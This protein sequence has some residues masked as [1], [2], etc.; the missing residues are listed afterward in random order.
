MNHKVIKLEN[1]SECEVIGMN[2]SRG[3]KMARGRTR[4][5]LSPDDPRT[6]HF[7]MLTTP[8]E[9]QNHQSNDTTPRRFYSQQRKNHGF[10]RP[11]TPPKR[12]TDS[13]SFE[14]PQ[15]SRNKPN[16]R[17]DRY[18]RYEHSPR[19][20]NDNRY[21]GESDSRRNSSSTRDVRRRQSPSM[22]VNRDE[23]M[24]PERV[25]YKAFKQVAGVYGVTN[26]LNVSMGL[27]HFLNQKQNESSHLDRQLKEI[28]EKQ[29]EIKACEQR[30]ENSRRRISVQK[31]IR[32]K[33]P[34]YGMTSYKNSSSN[35]S[36]CSRNL[37]KEMNE[38][39]K[40][41]DRRHRESKKFDPY[42]SRNYYRSPEKEHRKPEEKETENKRKA[43]PVEQVLERMKDKYNLDS[44][45]LNKLIPIGRYSASIS[46][47]SEEGRERHEKLR[48]ARKAAEESQH[49]HAISSHSIKAY[50]RNAQKI[51]DTINC[52][53]TL[54][55][56][57]IWKGYRYVVFETDNPADADEA[58]EVIDKILFEDMW[59]DYDDNDRVSFV[60]TITPRMK[61]ALSLMKWP[62]IRHRGVIFNVSVEKSERDSHDQNPPILLKGTL[63][64]IEDFRSSMAHEIEQYYRTAITE[65]YD[66]P[67][68]HFSVFVGK[69]GHNVKALETNTETSI[70]ILREE[71]KIKITAKRKENIDR[72]MRKVDEL[73]ENDVVKKHIKIPLDLTGKLIGVNGVNISRIRRESQ[74]SC[75]LEEEIHDG[76]KFLLVKGTR[77]Q[78]NK[79]FFIAYQMIGVIPM[80][81]KYA[82]FSSVDYSKQEWINR[83]LEM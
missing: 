77:E 62:A 56:R 65:E 40:R 17:Y 25:L 9:E 43:E 46:E 82:P 32:E 49:R 6:M 38:K 48:E 53:M 71:R 73:T 31:E 5:E 23:R 75:I 8:R 27:G 57:R 55:S 80:N 4:A 54:D 13:R 37:F 26:L 52:D 7:N 36:K 39:P 70:W 15:F 33:E 58:R 78:L 41:S 83:Q 2:D 21:N 51:R 34:A 3:R 24:S 44:S 14:R 66:F 19:S 11:F 81:E 61:Q 35:R 60:Y 28:Y 30:L 29:E 79:A 45:Q 69:F 76:Y 72:V 74:A 1:D 42:P 20:Y 10:Q 64:E 22:R 12:R 68:E 67:M 63:E 50:T 16:R 47:L 59:N 18:N